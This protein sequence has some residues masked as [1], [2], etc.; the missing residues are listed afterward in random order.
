[1]NDVVFV[2][3]CE[4]GCRIGRGGWLCKGEAC[5]MDDG[6]RCD[7]VVGHMGTGTV[8]DGGVCRIGAGVEV[9]T[10]ACFIG[11]GGCSD[12]LVRCG[13]GG[14]GLPTSDGERTLA[15]YEARG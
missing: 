5:R 14:G 12:E 8:V 3:V 15:G 1:M 9:E 7:S 4:G 2:V 13:G 6:M 11:G 10:G